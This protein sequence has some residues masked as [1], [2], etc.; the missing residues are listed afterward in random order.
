MYFY[1]VFFHTIHTVAQ[2]TRRANF[3]II[4]E[5]YSVILLLFPSLLPVGC[6][7]HPKVIIPK[8]SIQ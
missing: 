2:K 4:P 8:L 6:F 3:T 7:K 5:C 1:C